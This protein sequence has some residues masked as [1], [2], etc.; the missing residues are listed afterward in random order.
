[1]VV[2]SPVFT[3]FLLWQIFHLSFTVLLILLGHPEYRQ[4]D[5]LYFTTSGEVQ[6]ICSSFSIL[7]FLS[8]LHVLRT[9]TTAQEEVDIL[10][11]M[12]VQHRAVP[13]NAYMS[14]SCDQSVCLVT[15]FSEAG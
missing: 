15:M 8:V 9:N 2:Y 13:E 12:V 5:Y 1:M 10:Y 7:P 4:T 14:S 11:Q 3:S 6:I